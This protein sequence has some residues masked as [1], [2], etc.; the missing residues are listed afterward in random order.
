MRTGTIKL[1]GKTYL[2]CISARV[3]IALEEKM[4]AEADTALEHVLTGQESKQLF[5]LLAQ[6]ID[7]GDRYAKLEGLDNPGTVS[8]EELID[9]V[10]LDDLQN[11]F[12]DTAVAAAVSTKQKVETRA[13]KNAEATLSEE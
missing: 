7:A 8:E 5:W 10:G 4:G 1:R 6:M 12:R 3:M 9:L 11:L 13:P 2:V